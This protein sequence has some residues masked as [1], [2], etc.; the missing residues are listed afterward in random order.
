MIGP[1]GQDI[2]NFEGEQ[3]IAKWLT[4]NQL[5]VGIQAQ[6]LK[7]NAQPA[8]VRFLSG[9]GV[10]PGSNITLVAIGTQESYLIEIDPGFLEIAAD[11]ARTIQI[12]PI[13]TTAGSSKR[14]NKQ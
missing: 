6:V 12:L 2:P 9:E 10:R 1:G 4:L 14:R 7:I 8:V 5:E 13:S 3:V 11:I